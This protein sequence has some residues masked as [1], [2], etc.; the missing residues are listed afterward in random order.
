[1]GDED[2]T[3]QCYTTEINFNVNYRGSTG[4]SNLIE[5]YIQSV[6]HNQIALDPKQLFAED[7]TGLKWISNDEASSVFD[8]PNSD[9]GTITP[10]FFGPDNSLENGDVADIDKVTTPIEPSNDFFA[11]FAIPFGTGV[12]LGAI[13]F[14]I[15][16]YFVK[17]RKTRKNQ[18]HGKEKSAT[19]LTDTQEN[20]DIETGSAISGATR[21]LESKSSSV[22]QDSDDSNEGKTCVDVMV[23]ALGLSPVVSSDPPETS[24]ETSTP[25]K[26]RGAKSCPISVDSPE[27]SAAGLPPRPMTVKRAVSKQLKK[28]RKKKKRKK[29]QV[30]ALTRINSRDNITEMPI[31]SESESECDSECDSGDEE[32]CDDGSSYDASTGC[33]TPGRSSAP[34]S[35]TSSRASSP[36]KSPR[37]DSFPSDPMD[38]PG[39]EFVM[40]A[41][42]FSNDRFLDDG[43]KQIIG[44][45]ENMPPNLALQPRLRTRSEADNAKLRL[46]DGDEPKKDRR[47][48]EIDATSSEMNNSFAEENGTVMERMLPLPWLANGRANRM[49]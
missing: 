23:K 4:E 44:V 9:L 25:T 47:A 22:T 33:L 48:L 3:S 40:E 43:K 21:E 18:K 11:N 49:K 32:Y 6:I 37:D 15:H 34:R 45:D 39:F 29:K 36:Q 46:T 16:M 26:K 17:K 42:E 28:T 5:E 2:T 30:L 27:R 19:D 20:K 7:I 14:C 12:I 41:P 13:W 35:R 8:P 31:I 38:P 24:S 1:M 10:I